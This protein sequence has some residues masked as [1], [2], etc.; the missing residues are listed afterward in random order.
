M[1]KKINFITYIF[2]LFWQGLQFVMIFERLEERLFRRLPASG[3]FWKTSYWSAK[4]IFIWIARTKQTKKDP[5]SIKSVTY[6]LQWW[7]LVQ[8]YLTKRRSK[9]YINHVV[10]PLSSADIIIFSP[11]IRKFYYIKKYR[12]GLHFDT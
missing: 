3:Y 7:N 2:H 11:E 5:H 4:F 8:L 12:Y 1:R 10:H 9:T 6:I